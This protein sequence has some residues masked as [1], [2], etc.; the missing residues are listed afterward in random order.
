VQILTEKKILNGDI[1]LET[2]TRQSHL[3]VRQLEEDISAADNNTASGS[4]DKGWPKSSI[5]EVNHN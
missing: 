4:W 2:L 5:V 3:A 1:F